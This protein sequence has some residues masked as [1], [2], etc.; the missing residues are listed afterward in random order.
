MATVEYFSTDN[1]GLEVCA[2]QVKVVVLGA[3][4]RDGALEQDVAEEWSKSHTIVRRTKSFFRTLTDLFRKT[5]ESDGV[6][7]LVVKLS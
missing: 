6:Y 1:A 4:V 3:L 2:D 7:L 5:E